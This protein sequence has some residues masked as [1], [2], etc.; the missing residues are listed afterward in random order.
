M[1]LS[2][3]VAALRFAADKNETLT[4]KTYP[5]KQPAI[6]RHERM[7]FG[8]FLGDASPFPHPQKYFHNDQRYHPLSKPSPTDALHLLQINFPL[9]K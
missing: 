2:Y 9:F 7:L 6:F 8:N 5:S 1:I 4:V 3:G